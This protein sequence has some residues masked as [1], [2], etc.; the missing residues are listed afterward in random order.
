MA[1]PPIAGEAPT[2]ILI[3]PEHLR[4]AAATY[5]AAATSLLDARTGLTTAAA[6]NTMPGDLLDRVGQLLERSVRDLVEQMVYLK[7]EAVSMKKRAH[8]IESDEVP[9]NDLMLELMVK[10]PDGLNERFKMPPPPLEKKHWWDKGVPGFFVG[11]GKDLAGVVTGTWDLA[12][13]FWDGDKRSE[14]FGGLGYGLHHPNK[15]WDV[16]WDESIDKED[17]DKGNQW[18]A[19]GWTVTE[20]LLWW[21]GLDVT[22]L[23]KFSKFE[24]LGKLEKLEKLKNAAHARMLT[25]ATQLA[26]DGRFSNDALKR[27]ETLTGDEADKFARAASGPAY[28]REMESRDAAQAASRDYQAAQRNYDRWRRPIKP[29]QLS[30]KPLYIVDHLQRL[31]DDLDKRYGLARGGNW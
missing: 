14:F 31:S 24:K 23:A 8:L 6:P 28:R 15:A 20:A 29:A 1:A 12:S 25:T 13:L 30:E 22:K 26:L 10:A 9:A 4:T 3:N 17:R 16:L 21:P 27:W 5:H 18:E 19:N 11:A 7:A 2:T